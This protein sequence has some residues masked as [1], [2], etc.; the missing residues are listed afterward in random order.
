MDPAVQSDQEDTELVQLE[1]QVERSQLFTHT[2]LGEGF[3]RIGETSAFLH[4]LIDLLLSKGVVTEEEL[5][6]AVTDVRRQMT[7]Q[8]ELSGPGTLIRLEESPEEA[9]RTIKVD[10]QARLHICHAVCCKLDFALTIS[11]IESGTVKWDL[12][13]PYHIRHEQNGYCAHFQSNTEGCRIYANR[14]GVCRH[15]SCAR[16]GRIW[17]D[18]DK[19]ELNAEWLA[20]N[21]PPDAPER[22]VG[23]MME[24][25][26]KHAAVSDIS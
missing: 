14:P 15:Y 8:G 16:D 4:G 12:G 21:L 25:F 6:A 7:D 20:A 26:E 18:F 19:M 22:R 23:T 9:A 3:A 17:K 5:R 2:A 1:R 10:C 13:R 24:P 11:E